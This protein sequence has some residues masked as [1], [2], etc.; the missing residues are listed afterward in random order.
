MPRVVRCENFEVDRSLGQLRKGSVRV[1]LLGRTE[2]ARCVLETLHAAAEQK[3]YVPPSTLAWTYLGLG[4]IDDAFVWLDRAV[5][6]SDRMMVPI[7]T[8]PFLDPLRD[9]PRFAELLR[10]MKLTPVSA[11]THP[12]ADG[13]AV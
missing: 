6:V 5:D 7:Q 1:H 10:K 11:A 12:A 8:Y 9:D 2:E 13:A 3:K 4:A